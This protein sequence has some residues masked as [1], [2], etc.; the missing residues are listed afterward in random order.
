M[1]LVSLDGIEEWPTSGRPW[2]PSWS[3]LRNFSDLH[4]PRRHDHG[5]HLRDL[6]GFDWNISYSVNAIRQINV[7]LRL[8]WD[9]NWFWQ[10]ID[11]L[12]I[13]VDG[14]WCY[15]MNR[16]WHWVDRVWRKRVDWI[17]LWM[18]G[19]LWQGPD[20]VWEWANGM[21]MW[22]RVNRMNR[23][24]WFWLRVNRLYRMNRLYG[25]RVHGMNRFNGKNRFWMGVHGMNRFR[26]SGWFWVRF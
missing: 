9:W 3:L 11:W 22:I 6:D 13:G 26:V 25:M 18:N 16:F 5:S 21:R 23:M 17:R 1:L 7:N 12:R 2:P 8:N 19:Y 24:N 20:R 15:R 10:R 4:K 14:K